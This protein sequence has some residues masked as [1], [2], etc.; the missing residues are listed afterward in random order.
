LRRAIY[1]QFGGIIRHVEFNP[2]DE[3]GV[4]HFVTTQ[5]VDGILDANA[6]DASVDQSKRKFRHVA[7][8]PL[9]VLD[10]LLRTGKFHDRAYMRRFLNDIDNRRLRTWQGRL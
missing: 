1:D 7:R 8:I 10:E 5:D 6:R 3:N 4:T 2:N 9:A